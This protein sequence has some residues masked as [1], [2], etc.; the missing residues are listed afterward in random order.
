MSRQDLATEQ[1]VFK[2]LKA[3]PR[4][5]RRLLLAVSGGVDSM[6]MCEILYK[7]RQGLRLEL[8]VAH[9]HHGRAKNPKQAAYRKRAQNFVQAWATERELPFFTNTPSLQLL[10]SEAEFRA[11][12]EAY[13]SEWKSECQAD[14][15]AFAHHR[16]D[17]LE[18]RLIR[19]IR[20]SGTQGLRSMCL[21]RHGK[22]RPLLHVGASD[23]RE[24]ARIKKRKWIE[25]PSNAQTEMLRNWLRRDWLPLLETKRPGAVRS[26]ARSLETVSPAMREFDLASHVGLRRDSLTSAPMETRKE[27]LARYLKG[28]GLKGYAHAHVDEILKRLATQR[29]DFEFEMLGLNFRVSSDFLWASRV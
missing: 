24:Y 29:N 14:A 9:V 20:G 3:L 28:L 26:L 11:L 19:L 27:I 4:P 25:D 17:L 16:D 1:M 22:L 18:T 6:V 13:L 10:H 12:R 23:I 15:I 21:Y 8:S 7:W 2:A 5:P